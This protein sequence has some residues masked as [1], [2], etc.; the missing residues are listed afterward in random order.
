MVSLK[1]LFR[2]LE[3]G[4]PLKLRISAIKNSVQ[5]E[6]MEYMN[7]HNQWALGRSISTKLEFPSIDDA[8]WKRALID[9]GILVFA[10]GFLPFQK[11]L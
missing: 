5:D 8:D 6:I 2:T 1:T 11:E 9:E 7:Y 10:Q 3:L 4:N